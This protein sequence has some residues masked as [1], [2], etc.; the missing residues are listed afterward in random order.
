MIKWMC[1]EEYILNDIGECFF[2]SYFWKPLILLAH[3]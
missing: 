2:G 3:N 1:A